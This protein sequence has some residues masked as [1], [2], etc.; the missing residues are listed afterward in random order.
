MTRSRCCQESVGRFHKRRGWSDLISESGVNSRDPFLGALL[1]CQSSNNPP[2]SNERQAVPNVASKP[3]PKH[4]TFG[5]GETQKGEMASRR[6]FGES[7][8]GCRS[9][10][11]LCFRKTDVPS[12]AQRS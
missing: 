3:Q 7:A 5:S 1:G 9:Q 10:Q 4:D 8:M 6:I 11:Q 2:I 12:T